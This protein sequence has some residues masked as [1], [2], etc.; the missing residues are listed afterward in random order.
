L[1]RAAELP[2]PNR[3][4]KN[5]YNPSL[6]ILSEAKNLVIFNTSRSFTSFRMTIIPVFQHPARSFA[7]LRMTKKHFPE[8]KNPAWRL[9]GQLPQ[10]FT[11]FLRAA[12]GI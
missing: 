5:S 2:W 4:L 3:L 6:V 10:F 8:V 1:I 7:A 11:K 12:R 9:A